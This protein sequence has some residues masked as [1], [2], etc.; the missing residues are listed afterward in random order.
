MTIS[1]TKTRFSFQVQ[2]IFFFLTILIGS[3]TVQAHKVSSA[4]IILYLNTEDERTFTVSTQIEVES[5]GDAALDDEIGPEEAARTSAP[6]S[7]LSSP[8]RPTA[9]VENALGSRLD[10][11]GACW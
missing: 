10:D 3:S 11:D 6:K 7:G 5:S 1:Q 8:P 2:L 9:A 4:S